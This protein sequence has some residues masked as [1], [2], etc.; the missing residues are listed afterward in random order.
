MNPSEVGTLEL[1]EDITNLRMTD[2][3]HLTPPPPYEQTLGARNRLTIVQ[4][5]TPQIRL[6]ERVE[7]LE[8][9]VRRLEQALTQNNMDSVRNLTRRV[10]EMAESVREIQ[11]II[12]QAASS[13]IFPGWGLGAA[14]Q[15]R[16]GYSPVDA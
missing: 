1:E 4:D 8:T 7:T 9:R 5:Q 11:G 3:G 10:E 16:G 14:Q 13:G 15:T 2:Q 6:T 12:R